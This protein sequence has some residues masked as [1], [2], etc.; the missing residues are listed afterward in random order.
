MD[1][2]IRHRRAREAIPKA[3]PD[4]VP[5]SEENVRLPNSARS[6]RFDI[7]VAPWLREPLSRI[8][9]PG[10][11]IVTFVKPVQC[12]GSTV[13]EAAMN[14]RLKWGRGILQFNWQDDKRAQHRWD[15]RLEKTLRACPPIAAMIDALPRHKFN[16]CS[17]DFPTCFLQVQG[18]F[19][20]NNLDSDTVGF[21]INEEI[22]NWPPGHLA[23]ARNRQTAVW[24]AFALDISN[25]GK[26]GDQLHQAFEAG[27]QQPWEVRCPGC[28]RFHVMRTRWDHRRPELGGLVYDSDGCKDDDRYNYA[29]LAPTIRYQM[30]CGHVI[31]N[32]TTA[33]RKL[34][35]SGRYGEP[36]NPGAVNHRSYT[37]D[38]VACDFISWLTLI[39]EKHAAL[40]A[41]KY[42]DPEPWRRY[43]TERE[44]TFYNPDDVPIVG[45]ITLSTR[46]KDREGLPNRVVRFAAIDRQ[47]GLAS[48]REIPH[49]WVVVRDVDAAGNS[50]LVHEGKHHDDDELVGI[51]KRLEVQ[52]QHV[53]VDS[54]DDTT[55]VYLFCMKHGYSAIKGD[56]AANFT[57]PDGARKIFSVDRPLH[58]MLGAYPPK[59]DYVGNGVPDIREPLFWL[60]SKHGIAERLHYLRAGGAVKHEVPS[61]VSE[62]YLAHQEAEELQDYVIPKTGERVKVFVQIKTRND[63]LVC[64]RYIAML[65]DMAGLIGAEANA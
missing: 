43:V 2:A 42:G 27:T 13:G 18:A 53:V 15:S 19:N 28:N 17:A 10:T 34:S 26:Q 64:E 32:D 45:K 24:N 12:G 47:Q 5:W 37:L 49:W 55:N 25:A 57:H 30:P 21:Q 41:R 65:M 11:R 40:R 63:L 3:I 8:A 51:L 35:L 56:G 31:P 4:P 38:A 46:P 36:L 6:E 44:C 16:K 33:R 7:S 59:Y 54:G 60:Y 50:L 14:Y 62:D 23:K 20:A 29:K 9:D 52:P 22:H 39:Q 61:D 58:L 1:V 48:E